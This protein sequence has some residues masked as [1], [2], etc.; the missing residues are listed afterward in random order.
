MT[1]LK[2]A[3]RGEPGGSGKTGLSSRRR[4]GESCRMHNG[5]PRLIE[6]NSKIRDMPAVLG[7]AAFLAMQLGDEL[8]DGLGG[9]GAVSF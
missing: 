5:A 7:F 9:L 8:S 4:L 2:E 6:C 3:A 1:R